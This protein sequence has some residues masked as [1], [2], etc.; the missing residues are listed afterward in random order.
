MIDLFQAWHL[1]ILLF[2]VLLPIAFLIALFVVI[3][4]VIDSNKKK[5][6]TA[7]NIV[8][9][10]YARGEIDEEEFRRIKQGL[11]E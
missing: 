9:E 2:T 11:S 10:R 1:I 6:D 3:A 7:L 4:K 8:K 5:T